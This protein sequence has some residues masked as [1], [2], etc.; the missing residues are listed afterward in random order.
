MWTQE[1]FPLQPA[2]LALPYLRE[3]RLVRLDLAYFP[4]AV[5]A[6]LCQLTALDLSHDLFQRLPAALTK[7]TSLKALDV[8]KN[9][10]E[11]HEDNWHL[12]AALS[13]LCAVTMLEQRNR[14]YSHHGRW[15]VQ[16]QE[17]LTR[18]QPTI[19]SFSNADLELL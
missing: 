4:D 7:I 9:L 12:L 1:D 13:N 8:S 6:R 18:L 3:L 11:D 17:D 10:L 14:H 15:G 19:E 16:S 2:L 5:A